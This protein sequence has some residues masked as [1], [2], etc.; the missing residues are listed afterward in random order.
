MNPSL[1]S[2][3]PKDESYAT[4]EGPECPRCHAVWTADGQEYYD[5]ANGMKIDCSCGAKLFVQPFI[6]TSWTTT[7]IK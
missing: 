7:V 6:D 5:E 3:D 2:D 1:L 4:G